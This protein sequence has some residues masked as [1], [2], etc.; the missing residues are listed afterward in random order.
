MLSPF[1]FCSDVPPPFNF[2]LEGNIF[3]VVLYATG[4]NPGTG[5]SLRFN[6]TSVDR[7]NTTHLSSFSNIPS[8]IIGY[9]IGGNYPESVA[10]T[11]NIEIPSG[12]STAY[13]NLDI[14]SVGLEGCSNTD[15]CSCDALFIYE[16]SNK[17]VLSTRARFCSDATNEIIENA[18]SRLI[19]AFYSDDSQ[20][21][22]NATGFTLQYYESDVQPEPSSTTPQPEGGKYFIISCISNLL[23][24]IEMYESLFLCIE[25]PCGSVITAIDTQ[26]TYK[27]SVLYGQNE[28][29]VWTVR[30]PGASSYRVNVSTYGVTNLR[31][32]LSISAFNHSQS[33]TPETIQM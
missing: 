5:F 18:S 17:G 24:G 32:G 14:L 15:P 2:T 19:L 26:I 9:P 21:P 28:R 33:L 27:E 20:Q 6:G 12:N 13:T 31:D 10:A 22:G 4:P 25:I 8:G 30:V 3:A 1:R 7:L 11:W 23:K 29:C 16:I